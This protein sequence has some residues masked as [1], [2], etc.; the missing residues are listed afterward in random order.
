MD[1]LVVKETAAYSPYDDND[2]IQFYKLLGIGLLVKRLSSFV[3]EKVQRNEKVWRA[4]LI[5]VH[6][7]RVS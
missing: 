2:D 5:Y 1:F 4:S 6:S 7:K 3:Y